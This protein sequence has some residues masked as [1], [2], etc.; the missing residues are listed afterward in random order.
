MSRQTRATTVVSQ[1]AEVVD[2]AGV[3]AAQPQPGFLNRVVGLAA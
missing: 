1:P 3:G 2:A